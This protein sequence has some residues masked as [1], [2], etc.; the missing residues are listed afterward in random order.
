MAQ[1]VSKGQ[2]GLRLADCGGCRSNIVFAPS[3]VV[4]HHHYSGGCKEVDR[5]IE[6]PCCGRM[7]F[8]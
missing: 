5:A 7:V 8:V 6:C 4:E 3:D 2:S 1:V